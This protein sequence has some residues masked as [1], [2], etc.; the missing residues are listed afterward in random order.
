MAYDNKRR[1]IVTGGAGMIGS[2]LVWALNNRGIDNILIVDRLGNDEKW[3]NLV[4]LQ[5][6]DYMD[7]ELFLNTVKSKGD[8]L[9]NVGAVFH[10]GACSS[11]TET[12]A[13]YLM[14]NNFAYTREL[15]NWAVSRRYRFLYASSAATY[16]DGEHGMSDQKDELYDLRPLNMYGYSKHLFDCHA[17]QRGISR[18]IVGLKFFN[19]FGPNEHH[20][21]EMRSVVYKGYQQ[22][23][24]TGRLQLFKSH[25]PDFRDGEQKR[26]F[27]YVKDA[28][29]MVLHLAE[30][31]LSGGLFNIGSGQAQTWLEL[32]HA[33]FSALGRA[34]QIDFVDMPDHLR[35]KYQYFTQADMD[36]F[37]ASDYP[38]PR[39]PLNEAVADYLQ[40]YLM[41]GK[42]LGDEPWEDEE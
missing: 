31:P 7:A 34:P 8:T 16:G 5:Y 10:M 15:A 14:E 24:E 9:G 1:Y 40:N 30:R 42:H 18:G 25:R 11:T 29:E 2:A 17:A 21:G 38:E 35:A 39:T 3:K 28:V 22:I 33:I 12:D 37:N 36:K 32:G 41:V 20:K 27:L 4:P 13:N 6:A 23:V 19:I 26:D